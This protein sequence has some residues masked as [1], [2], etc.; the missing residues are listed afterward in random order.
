MPEE[1]LLYLAG[2][3]DGGLC[4]VNCF[5]NY[6]IDQRILVDHTVVIDLAESLELR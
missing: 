6:S 1:K 5:K 4:L 2:V 3:F